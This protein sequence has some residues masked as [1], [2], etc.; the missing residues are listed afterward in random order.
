MKLPKNLPLI[1]ALILAMTGVTR[2]AEDHNHGHDHTPL[3]GG[4]VTEVKD[5][6][7]ELV[8]KPEVLQLHVRDHGKPVDVS[9]ASAQV[10]LL[11]GTER[12]EAELRPAG[13]KLESAGSYKIGTGTKAVVIVTLPGK[14]PVTARFV[15]P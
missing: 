8:A 6:D 11:T 1:A 2:A 9:Q 4:I 7:Y 14:A 15:V 10:T 5:R 3:H 13:D 12:Q